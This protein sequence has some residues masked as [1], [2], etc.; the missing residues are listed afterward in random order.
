MSELFLTDPLIFF[1]S[2]VVSGEEEFLVFPKVFLRF[3]AT[4]PRL[5]PDLESFQNSRIWKRYIRFTSFHRSH[6]GKWP[7]LLMTLTRFLITLKQ[8]KKRF[9]FSSKTIK[10]PPQKK[11]KQSKN[12]T[13]Q[14]KNKNKKSR[15][16]RK[17]NKKMWLSLEETKKHATLPTYKQKSFLMDAAKY[18]FKAFIETTRKTKRWGCSKFLF[19][20][21]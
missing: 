6:F 5:L 18:V 13:E 14:N 12:Q 19:D 11:K 16:R 8:L 2:S 7:F 3:R 20:E 21:L 10:Y 17:E 15:K 9:I 1:L 4:N